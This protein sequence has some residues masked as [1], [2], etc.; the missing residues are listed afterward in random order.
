MKFKDM[1]YNKKIV[2]LC[3]TFCFLFINGCGKDDD[4]SESKINAQ[5]QTFD[6]NGLNNCNTSLGTGSTFVLEIPYSAPDGL[7]INRLLIKSTVSDGTSDDD[8]NTQ[9]T[10]N[11]NTITWAVCFHFGSQ[12][13]VEYEVRLESADG[14]TSNISKVRINKPDGAQ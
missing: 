12:E 9:F 6:I 1:W 4:N 5:S 2:L 14:K 7:T 13:W 11:G 3:L 8:V 10:D